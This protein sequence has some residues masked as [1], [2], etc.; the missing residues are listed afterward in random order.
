MAGPYRAI[1]FDLDGTLIDENAG[2]GEA[3]AAVAAALRA[4]GH[5]VDDAMSRWWW[6]NG[7]L[8]DHRWLAPAPGTT[9]RG[10]EDY[11]VLDTMDTRDD[12]DH[13]RAL[14]EARGLEFLVLDQT[15]PDI[16]MPV[17]RVIVPGMRHFWERFAP[18]RLFDVPVSMGLREHPLSE[19]QLNP[20]PV[21][22]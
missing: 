17:V 18:G 1:F 4:R 19:D 14:V 9:P 21:I 22:A 11:L 13:C 3:R 10:K 2:V 7:R 8:A 6:E 5:A 12:V 15:R 20:V 16:G